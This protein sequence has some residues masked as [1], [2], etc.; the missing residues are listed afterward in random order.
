M[1]FLLAQSDVS[2]AHRSCRQQ[3][4]ENI[5]I[6]FREEHEEIYCESVTFEYFLN[7]L[8]FNV[9]EHREVSNR[10]WLNQKHHGKRSSPSSLPTCA[11]EQFLSV[12]IC[13]STSVS[14][15]RMS[16]IF[17]CL[18]EAIVLRLYRFFWKHVADAWVLIFSYSSRLMYRVQSVNLNAT[19]SL[20]SC[21]SFR[22]V[23]SEKE[24]TFWDDI[25]AQISRNDKITSYLHHRYLSARPPPPPLHSELVLLDTAGSVI[26]RKLLD[27]GCCLRRPFD[28]GSIISAPWTNGALMMLRR[29]ASSNGE[30]VE[31]R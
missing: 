8:Q 18:I 22:S 20:S 6:F 25:G 3:R 1:G 7:G 26:S 10:K 29:D 27:A 30:M 21:I 23:H 9:I 12:Q 11:V 16:I 19:F 31:A 24:R 14:S 17:P 4:R 2:L 15:F 13:K 5:W 28:A